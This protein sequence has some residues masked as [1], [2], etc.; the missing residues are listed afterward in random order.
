MVCTQK[1]EKEELEQI[2]AHTCS[3]Q[4][5]SQQPECGSN[6]SFPRTDEWINKTYNRV[7]FSFKRGILAHTMMWMNPEGIMLG[8]INQLQKDKFYVIPLL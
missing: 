5:Y 7:L 2:F 4:H 1:N 8:E 3:H 6:P